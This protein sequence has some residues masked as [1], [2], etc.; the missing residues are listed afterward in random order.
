[1]IKAILFDFDGVLVDSEPLH[2]EAEKTL[3]EKNGGIFTREIFMSTL[4]RS[5]QDAILYYKEHFTLAPS[6]DDLMILHDRVF[7]ELVD[8]ALEMMPGAREL[9]EFLHDHGYMYA[10]ASSGTTAYIRKALQKFKL[11][12]L[13]ED[14]ITSIEM[15]TH[16]KPEPDIF[17]HAA[18]QLNMP[19]D[20]CLVIEDAL[21]GIQAASKA[22]MKSLFLNTDATIDIGPYSSKRIGSLSE[23]TL[24][25]LQSL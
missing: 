2:F 18:S 13:F 7:F 4:G 12:S 24:E 6:I 21:S 1:M 9:I 25:L 20:N 3:V 15:V 14:T 11:D 19:H 10:I 23:V 5:L 22:Y 16:G 8:T 17:V